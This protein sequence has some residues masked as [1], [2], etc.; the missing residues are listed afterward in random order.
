MYRTFLNMFISACYGKIKGENLSY[1]DERALDLMG[2]TRP[3][4]SDVFYKGYLRVLDFITG[5]TDN[6][7]T[8]IAG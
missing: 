4:E 5:M 3:T 1:K 8:F 7:A 2:V 6:Y